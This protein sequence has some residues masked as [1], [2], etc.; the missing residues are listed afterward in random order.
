MLSIDY[1]HQLII[2]SPINNIMYLGSIEPIVLS[3]ELLE[4]HDYQRSSETD[5]QRFNND[6]Q[7]PR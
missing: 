7:F 1:S 4:V 5:D 3:V 2:F 6:L